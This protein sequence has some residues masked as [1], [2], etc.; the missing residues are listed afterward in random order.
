MMKYGLISHNW[1]TVCDKQQLPCIMAYWFGANPPTPPPHYE[2]GEGLWL[3][4]EAALQTHS[5][6]DA[7]PQL[8]IR[9]NK[10]KIMKY[11]PK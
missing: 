5:L 3:Q 1:I 9:Q 11:T 2:S 4:G 7:D 10:T 6:R 8:V